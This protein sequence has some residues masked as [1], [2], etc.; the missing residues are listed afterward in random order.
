MAK[1]DRTTKKQFR[2]FE[3]ECRKWLDK[4]GLKDWCVLVRHEELEKGNTLARC[5]WNAE[6]RQAWLRLN[7]TTRAGDHEI[8]RAALHECLELLLCGCTDIMWKSA[9]DDIVD[10]ETHKVIRTLENLLVGGPR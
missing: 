7:T 3:K 2:I 1:C 4:L 8:K 10:A 9:A 5:N 6:Q